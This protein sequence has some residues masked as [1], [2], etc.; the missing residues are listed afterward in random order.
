MYIREFIPYSESSD[1]VHNPL[2][3][4]CVEISTANSR[5]FLVARGIDQP[6]LLLVYLIATNTLSR[7]AMWKIRK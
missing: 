4:L 5:S 6:I 3:M 2:G 7:N 1:Q